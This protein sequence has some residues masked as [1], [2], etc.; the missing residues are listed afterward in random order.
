MTKEECKMALHELFGKWA[1]ERSEDQ[2]KHPGF[3]DFKLWLSEKGFSH[4]MGFRS[5]IGAD[6]EVYQWFNSHFKQM[7]RE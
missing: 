4:Y 1:S 3:Y 6:E 5:S 7:W 2:L